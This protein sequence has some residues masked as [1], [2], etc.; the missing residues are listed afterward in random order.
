LSLLLQ[1][2]KAKFECNNVFEC[3]K[4]APGKRATSPLRFS[5]KS[6]YFCFHDVR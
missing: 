6:K 2:A 1:N 4:K 5:K 3:F